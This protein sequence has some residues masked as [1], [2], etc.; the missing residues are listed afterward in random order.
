MCEKRRRTLGTDGSERDGVSQPEECLSWL[1]RGTGTGSVQSSQ[2]S[3]REGDI[4]SAVRVL[5]GPD[6]VAFITTTPSSRYLFLF[7]PSPIYSI[8]PDSAD[9]HPLARAIYPHPSITP[10]PRHDRSRVREPVVALVRSLRDR[11]TQASYRDRVNFLTISA[12][13]SGK[14]DDCTS[15]R[16][17]T[18]NP[19]RAPRGLGSATRS[20]DRDRYRRARIRRVYTLRESF[21]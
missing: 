18:A 19:G 1:R 15:S 20:V 4:L 14:S 8:R 13:D 11:R 5:S 12:K 6:V 2:I 16:G 10:T 3:P 17:C 21:L 7:S 9:R